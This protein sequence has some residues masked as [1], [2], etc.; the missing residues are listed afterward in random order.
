MLF[1]GNV[2]VSGIVYFPRYSKYCIYTDTIGQLLYLKISRHRN[3]GI[4][5]GIV[6]EISYHAHH[7]F[8]YIF[9]DWASCVKYV[10]KTRR[11]NFYQVI[12]FCNTPRPLLN[13]L[14]AHLKCTRVY[15]HLLILIVST[16]TIN[17]CECTSVI[18]STYFK[19]FKRINAAL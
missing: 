17:K 5:S 15:S 9:L 8:Q 12:T 19:A 6:S 2:S 4:V 11:K 14:N 10:D 18:S 16:T 3:F 13:L 1:M 7:C